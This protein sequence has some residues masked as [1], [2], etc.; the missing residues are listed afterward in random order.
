MCRFGDESAAS[1]GLR[2]T[3]ARSATCGLTPEPAAPIART[4]WCALK[5]A[6]GTRREPFRIEQLFLSPIS[7]TKN[8]PLNNHF[9]RTATLSFCTNAPDLRRVV[10]G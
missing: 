2:R 9:L 1:H 3:N 4:A 6:A 7:V 5:V 8:W 10:A